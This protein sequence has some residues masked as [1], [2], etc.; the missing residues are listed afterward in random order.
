MDAGTRQVN[1]GGYGLLGK[2]NTTFA[3][4][5]YTDAFSEFNPRG[6]WCFFPASFLCL[7]KV[8][9]FWFQLGKLWLI[10]V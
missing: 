5:Y 7:R 1:D 6:C 9:V 8:S 2:T 4:S 3:S 10:G